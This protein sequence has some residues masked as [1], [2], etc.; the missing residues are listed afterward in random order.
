MVEADLVARARRR[1]E[2]ARWGIFTPLMKGRD[3]HILRDIAL[4]LCAVKN[5]H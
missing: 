3:V 4:F 1:A 5:P 2:C